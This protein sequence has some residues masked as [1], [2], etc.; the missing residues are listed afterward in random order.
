MIEKERLFQTEALHFEI[1][2]K[3]ILDDL[4]FSIYKNE[5]LAIVGESGSGKSLTALSLLGLQPKTNT[6]LESKRLEFDGMPMHALTEKDW[7]RIRGNEISMIFQ[8]PQSSLN[9]SMRCG[10]QVMEVLQRHKKESKGIQKA[11][12]LTAFED[13]KLPDPERIFNAY[14][15]QL[16][17]GQKQR[18]MIA[19]ALICKPKLLIADEPTTALDVTVQKE[20][21]ELLKDLQQKTKMSILFIS[22]DLGLVKSFAHRVL[23]MYQGRIIESGDTVTLFENPQQPYTKGLL[24]ARPKMG[25]RLKVLPTLS[26]YENNAFA[27]KIISDEERQEHLAQLYKQKPILEVSNLKKR[28]SGS[29]AWFQ[30]RTSVTAVESVDFSLYPGETLGLVGESGCGKSSLA[31]AL[32]YLDPPTSGTVKYQGEPIHKG[33]K[34]QLVA[35]RKDMQ[36]V[37]QDPYAALNPVMTIG[38]AIAEPLHVHNIVTS[39]TE[40]KQRTLE[41]LHQVGLSDDFEHRYP[42]ELSGGQRQRVVIARALATQPRLLICDEAVAALD[43]SVQ[44]QVLNLLN[45]LKAELGLSYLFISHDLSVVKFMSDRI[46]VMQNGRLVELQDS[47]ALYEQPEK[48]YTKKLI[49]AI[50]A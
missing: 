50:P 12:V 22:H 30:K 35:L 26:D 36:F 18:V 20:I 47:D 41:L 21:V 48:D 16:S 8:E 28:Y 13:V 9:P 2:G 38:K 24:F 17:G 43:I 7:E 39:K 19:M 33:R 15:H 14:P 42:H 32:I 46:M 45:R 5:I 3:S 1:Q 23:V 4:Q 49:A 40:R 10:K 29:H 25:E 6:R 11:L 37:F 27:P 44:A 31:K 34:S